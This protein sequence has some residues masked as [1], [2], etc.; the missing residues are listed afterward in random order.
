MNRLEPGALFAEAELLRDLA[1][2]QVQLRADR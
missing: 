2:E 1:L